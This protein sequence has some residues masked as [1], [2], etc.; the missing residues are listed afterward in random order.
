MRR[1]PKPGYQLLADAIVR[2][3]VMDLRALRKAGLIVG[4][5]CAGGAWPKR[6]S[7]ENRRFVYDY[8]SWSSVKRLLYWFTRPMDE[9]LQLLHVDISPQAIRRDLGIDAGEVGKYGKEGES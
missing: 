2:R 8:A 9:L 5:H 6:E 1:N 7:G 3:E 4:S